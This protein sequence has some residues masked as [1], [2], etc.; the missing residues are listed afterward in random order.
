MRRKNTLALSLHL[1]LLLSLFCLAFSSDRNL[2][3]QPLPSQQ[4]QSPT[5]SRA[6]ATSGAKAT[7]PLTSGVS[8]TGPLQGGIKSESQLNPSLRLFPQ[9]QGQVNGNGA[10]GR[11]LSPNTRLIYAPEQIRGNVHTGGTNGGINRR[12][13]RTSR[14][15]SQRWQWQ[16]VWAN[17]AYFFLQPVHQRMASSTTYLALTSRQYLTVAVAARSIRHL[18]T[19]RRSAEA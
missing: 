8:S 18:A 10:F 15:H 13:S 4:R 2:L 7:K 3:Y 16:N 19:T 14:R 11:P 6:P 9:F 1:P 17:R 5:T 12:P